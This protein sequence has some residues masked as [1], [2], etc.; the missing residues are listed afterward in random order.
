MIMHWNAFRTDCDA[1]TLVSTQSRAQKASTIGA[2]IN[3]LV[4][5]DCNL[6]ILCATSGV[7][8]V[9]I[10][11]SE[12][13]TVHRIDFPPYI[14]DM[15]QEIGRCGRNYEATPDKII[16]QVKTYADSFLHVWKRINDKQTRAG[17]PINMCYQIEFMDAAR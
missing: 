8:N 14:S 17:N 6:D 11:C 16:H 7:G 2:F 12:I 4:G 15:S 3:G 1:L 9:G 5:V 13:L 10:D